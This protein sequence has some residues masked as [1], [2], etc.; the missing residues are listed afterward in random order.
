MCKIIAIANQKGGVAKTTT[1]IN[2]GV[3]LSKV[4]K[5]VMLIDADPQGHLTM[6]LGFPKNLRVTLKTMMENIIMGLE[7]DPR[8]AILHHEEGIDVI[9]SNKLLSGMDMSLFTVEDREKVLKEY[10][11]LLENDYDYILIDCMPSLG[12]MTINALVILLSHIEPLIYN[13]L[14][15]TKQPYSKVKQ[16]VKRMSIDENEG[17]S[18]ESV[19]KLYVMGITYVVFANTDAY[20]KEIDK[21]IPFRNNILHNG[22][23]EYGT[24]DIHSAYE[25]L[26]EFISMLV[27]IKKQLI[28]EKTK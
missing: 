8:E 14:N 11:E 13:T 2:L 12:M 9:P 20:T 10:L 16:I 17:M 24:D 21:R 4:G 19:G 23:V 7:F 15:Y 18:S 28:N 5:R 3:G 1:T 6:G 26:V 27:F 25:L 22:I